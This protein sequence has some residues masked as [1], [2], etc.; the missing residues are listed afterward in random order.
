M[1]D[2]L[3]AGC[4][5]TISTPTTFELLVILGGVAYNKLLNCSME[6]R[7]PNDMSMPP[8]T[9]ENARFFQSLFGIN[10]A[11]PTLTR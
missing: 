8:H 6:L 5:Q 3:E 4:R 9:V 11:F 7:T 1:L 10:A 2:F